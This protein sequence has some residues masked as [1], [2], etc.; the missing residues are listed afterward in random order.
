MVR[1]DST[2]VGL[3]P[4]PLKTLRTRIDVIEHL[5]RVI[6]S[7]VFAV[8]SKLPSERE[9]CAIY[10]V[11]RPVIRETLAGL[12]ER[13]YIEVYP[14]RGSFVRAVAVDELAEPLSRA[15]RQAGITARHLV[16][17]RL[18]LECT[19]AE[20][21]AERASD[22]D[23]ARIERALAEHNAAHSLADRAHTDLAFHEAVAAA[24]GNPVIALMFGAIRTQ[25]HALMLRSLSDQ[26]VRD[27]GD[28]M[29][30][31]IAEAIAARDP[32][33]ARQ[34]M[35]DH[36]ELALSLYGDDLDLSLAAVLEGRGLLVLDAALLV[37]G[38]S[39]P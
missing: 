35:R 11:S 19:A 10:D 1:E 21:A 17:A 30:E 26:A 38:T 3:I 2:A 33:G 15:T 7:G 6:L 32:D 4:R 36:I 5:E 20:L 14:G 16:S 12:V 28:P 25:V 9:L 13:G 34:A 22:E 8:G 29:H 23:V 39:Q 27:A 31:R 24:S 18:M 37:D